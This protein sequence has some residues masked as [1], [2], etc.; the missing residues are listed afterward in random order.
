[1]FFTTTT[2]KLL[3]AYAGHLMTVSMLITADKH[4]N[5]AA[6]KPDSSVHVLQKNKSIC[7]DERPYLCF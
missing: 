4:Y 6:I 7:V 5:D 2:Q 1:L 3:A